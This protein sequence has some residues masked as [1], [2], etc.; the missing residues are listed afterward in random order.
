[1]LSWPRTASSSTPATLVSPCFFLL[2]Q[3]RQAPAP[4]LVLLTR[5]CVSSHED[6]PIRCCF[7]G[8]ASLDLC[9]NNACGTSSPRLPPN[10]M[11]VVSEP[12]HPVPPHPHM[13]TLPKVLVFRQRNKRLYN[14]YSQKNPKVL[15]FRQRNKQLYNNYY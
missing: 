11:V 7:G 9:A 6:D 10:Q 2:P 14:N 3:L 12:S 5:A 8:Q 4:L 1:V 13:Q 15:V